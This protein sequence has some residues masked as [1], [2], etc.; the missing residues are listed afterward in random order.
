MTEASPLDPLLRGRSGKSAA[1]WGT[2]VVSTMIEL[3]RIP[4]SPGTA[5]RREP[6]TPLPE[7]PWTRSSENEWRWCAAVRQ[8]VPVE[9]SADC[10]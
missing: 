3:P 6:A 8:S 9:S 1:E 2:N 7:Q 10:G 5:A 4:N